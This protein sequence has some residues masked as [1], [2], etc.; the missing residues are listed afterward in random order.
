MCTLSSA[1]EPAGSKA[2]STEAHLPFV[3]RLAGRMELETESER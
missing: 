3:V 2:Q 1:Q